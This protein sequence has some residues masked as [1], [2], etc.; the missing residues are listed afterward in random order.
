MVEALELNEVQHGINAADSPD[1][2]N[3]LAGNQIRLNACP[4]S[5]VMLSRTPD[6]Q[7]HPIRRLVDCGITVTINFEIWQYRSS[8][9]NLKSLILD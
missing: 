3:W 2:M 1:V 9:S 8:T 4:T 6:L 5:N 7:R